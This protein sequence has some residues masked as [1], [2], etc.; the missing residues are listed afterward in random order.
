MKK[1]VFTILL[2][3]MSAYSFAQNSQIIL[4]DLVHCQVRYDQPLNGGAPIPKSPILVPTVSLDDHTLY[5]YDANKPAPD[6]FEQAVLMLETKKEE[7]IVVGGSLHKGNSTVSLP[8]GRVP[9]CR[10]TSFPTRRT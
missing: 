6:A 7:T 4:G 3:I 8:G 5:I 9:P 2:S 10:R 1:L